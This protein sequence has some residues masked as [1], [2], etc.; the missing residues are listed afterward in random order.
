[1]AS[2]FSQILNFL[3]FSSENRAPMPRYD[4]TAEAV[5]GWQGCRPL[6]WLDAIQGHYEGS[7][8]WRENRMLFNANA[9]DGVVDMLKVCPHID[10][11]KND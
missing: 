7:S 1:M 2:T 8:F 10:A 11:E 5:R 9:I 3:G 6:V 4:S